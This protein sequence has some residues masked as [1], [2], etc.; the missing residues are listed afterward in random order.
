MQT[1]LCTQHQQQLKQPIHY[2][3]T[4][5]P[6]SDKK[7]PGTLHRHLTNIVKVIQAHENFWQSK[8]LQ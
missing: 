7:T 2:S 8:G 1:G 4:Q 3:P 5:T 6:H